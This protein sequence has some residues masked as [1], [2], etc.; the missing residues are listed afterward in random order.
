MF[1]RAARDLCV[2]YES[3]FHIERGECYQK[4]L[5]FFPRNKNLYKSKVKVLYKKK[6]LS[7]TIRIELSCGLLS[8]ALIV[9]T[10]N[11]SKWDEHIRIANGPALLFL[12][13]R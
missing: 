10:L 4:T 1:C 6:Y 3:A 9:S 13:S 2:A 11:I 5:T 7:A 8:A 12:S